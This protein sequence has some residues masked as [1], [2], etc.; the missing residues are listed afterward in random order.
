MSFTF[1]DM[2]RRVRS[3][4]PCDLEYLLKKP[5]CWVY[6]TLFIFPDID[7]GSCNVAFGDLT[8]SVTAIELAELCAIARDRTDRE[9]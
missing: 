4:S 7:S 9:S 8:I 5:S 6:G 3:H 2:R 1:S